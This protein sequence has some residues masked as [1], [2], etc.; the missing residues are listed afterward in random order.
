MAIIQ[1]EDFGNTIEVILFPNVYRSCAALIQTDTPVVV[2]GR[3]QIEDET[4]KILAGQV[5]GLTDY[6]K[7]DEGVYVVI[8]KERETAGTE[9]ALKVIL[10]HYPGDTP[11]F[12]KLMGS[13]KILKKDR[14]LWVRVC[15]E[16]KQDLEKLLGKDALQTKK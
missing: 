4:A 15:D 8:P 2:R 7:Q 14:R 3:L 13:R 1:I 9:E 6:F 11:V 16:L 5:Y 10:S 12:Y